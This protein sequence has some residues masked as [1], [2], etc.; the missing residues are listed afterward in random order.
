MTSHKRLLYS[1]NETAE[2]LDMGV[3]TLRNAA[4]RWPNDPQTLVNLAQGLALSGE[5]DEARAMIGR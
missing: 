1:M 4:T 2:M 5:E 3:R